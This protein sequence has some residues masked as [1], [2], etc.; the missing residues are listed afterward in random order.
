MT[1]FLTHLGMLAVGLGGG[2]FLHYRFGASVKNAVVQIET[3]VQDAAK[4]L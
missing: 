3:R 1:T 2:W 4:K